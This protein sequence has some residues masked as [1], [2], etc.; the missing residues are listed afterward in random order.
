MFID[1][2]LW[3]N[4]GRVDD[5][6]LSRRMFVNGPL[7]TLYGIP[8][9]GLPTQ[10]IGAEFPEAEQRAGILTQPG[11]L[12][13]VSDPEAT[14]IVHRGLYVHNDILCLEPVPSPGDLLQQPEIKE[15]LATLTTE[16]ERSD[17]RMT[18]AMCA[19]CHSDIDPY[20]LILENFDPVGAYR[21]VADGVPIDPTGEFSLSPSLMGPVTGAA[22]FAQAVVSDGLFTACA[23]QKIAS[24]AIGRSIRART[25]CEVKEVHARFTS[26]DGTIQSLFRE[27]ALASFVR[28]R[29]GGDP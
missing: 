11:V 18:N 14:S 5:L 22:A 1:E 8:F 3:Q 6:I 27:V 7:A 23:A 24:Y 26:T 16:R 4:Y 13:A 21:T 9:S 29:A 25:T 12:W 28:T 17:F 2:V 19:G 10:F 20:S 15:A